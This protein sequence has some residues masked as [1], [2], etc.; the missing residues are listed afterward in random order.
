MASEKDLLHVMKSRKRLWTP[1][2]LCHELGI[3]VCELVRL[4][5]KARK[6]G[7]ALRC[8]N[9]SITGYTSKFWLAEVAEC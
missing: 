3:D 5:N 9:G 4:I 2:E 1:G 7:V 8:E 6:A